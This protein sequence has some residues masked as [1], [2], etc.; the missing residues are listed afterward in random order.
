[1]PPEVNAGSDQ[2][3]GE[4]AEVQLIGSAIDTLGVGISGYS[5]VQTSGTAVT[6]TGADSA[7][8][9]FT[10]PDVH[11]VTTLIFQLRVNLNNGA[12]GTDSVAIT[13]ENT[14]GSSDPSSSS[15]SSSVYTRAEPNSRSG[16]FITTIF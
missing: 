14:D 10:A 4:G 9:S 2:R 5:W 8:A 12:Y 6:L 1:M 7:A 3:V 16:C 15:S 13:V 11:A